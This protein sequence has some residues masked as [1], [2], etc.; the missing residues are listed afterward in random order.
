[1]SVHAREKCQVEGEPRER[2]GGEPQ[3]P[4]ARLATRAAGAGSCGGEVRV[5]RYGQGERYPG[6]PASGRTHRRESRGRGREAGW[7]ASEVTSR[8]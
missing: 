4:P 3:R 6:R 8:R 7:D 5:L 1:M 2:G